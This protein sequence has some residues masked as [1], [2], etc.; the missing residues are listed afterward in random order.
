MELPA[1]RRAT[2]R[3]LSFSS[4]EALLLSHQ[5]QYHDKENIH[6]ICVHWGWQ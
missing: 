4:P 5:Q 6:A 1:L 3:L 2:T